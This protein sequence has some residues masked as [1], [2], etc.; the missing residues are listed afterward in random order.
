M[1]EV[2]LV[3]HGQARLGTDDYDRLSEMG[4]E[5]S[6]RL[7][8]YFAERG[9]GFDRAVIGGLKRH[10]QTYDAIAEEYGPSLKSTTV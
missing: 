5:Q 1:P 4:V 2:Y 3:R 8:R 7:G 10:R 9:I 6:R